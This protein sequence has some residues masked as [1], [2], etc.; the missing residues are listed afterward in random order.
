[1]RLA[2]VCALLLVPV[3]AERSGYAARYKNGLMEQVAEN[4]GM[5]ARHMV[6]SPYEPLGAWVTVCS[7]RGCMRALVID[8]CHPRHCRR[9]RA[10][11]IVVEVSHQD[12]R[13]LCGS[14][15]DPPR[16]CP[17]VVSRR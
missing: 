1:M 6:A 5:W 13:W 4:R 2:V 17:V 10:K 9:I 12:A 14:V 16:Q 15:V 8:V 3:Q 11:G 7:R